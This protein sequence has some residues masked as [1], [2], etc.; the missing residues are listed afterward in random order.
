MQH[1]GI[2]R[3]YLDAAR[4]ILPEVI[5]LRRRLHGVPEVGLELPRTQ[6]IVLDAVR[7]LGLDPITGIAVGSVVATIEGSGPGPCYEGP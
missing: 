5:A 7:A 3:A 4:E 6:A 1:T 2:A